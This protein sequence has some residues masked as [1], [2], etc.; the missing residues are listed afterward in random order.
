MKDR[1]ANLRFEFQRN[2]EYS[3]NS[4]SG[5]ETF[6]GIIT[7]ISEAGIGLYVFKPLKVGQEITIEKG[8]SEYFKR[9]IVRWCNKMGDNV[10]R[11]G[12]MFI[13]K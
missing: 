1:R 6:E 8:I 7:D 12:M 11:A 4:G 2:I 3:L 9:G 5:K 13:R 10:Y